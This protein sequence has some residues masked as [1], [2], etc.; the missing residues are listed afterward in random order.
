MDLTSAIALSLAPVG[1]V[2]NSEPI[3]STTVIVGKAESTTPNLP[4]SS[5][6]NLK[7]SQNNTRSPTPSDDGNQYDEAQKQ[8]D[9]SG[10]TR[11]CLVCGQISHG[12]HFGILACRACAAFFRRTVVEKKSYKCRQNC[13]CVIL[14]VS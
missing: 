2:S 12:F 6:E 11:L 13:H 9:S 7:T 10:G 14:I 3:N 8:S 5:Q 1:T 4:H